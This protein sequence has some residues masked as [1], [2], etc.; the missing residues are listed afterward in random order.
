MFPANE[1]PLN[2]VTNHRDERVP[3][4]RLTIACHRA[5]NFGNLFSVRK[6]QKTPGPS[7]SSFLNG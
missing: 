7:V 2:M 3:I 5:P 1:R 4:D 6:I